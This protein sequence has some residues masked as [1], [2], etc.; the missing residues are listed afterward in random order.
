MKGAASG[1]GVSGAM[2]LEELLQLHPQAHDLVT[3]QA[4]PSGPKCDG[5]FRVVCNDGG[6]STVAQVVTD[7]DDFSNCAR[8]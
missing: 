8:Y 4:V 7:G 5:C 2:A 6:T 3:T 1:A